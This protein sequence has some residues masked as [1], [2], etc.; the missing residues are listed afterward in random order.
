M[1]HRSAVT[2]VDGNCNVFVLINA[3]LLC[4]KEEDIN[5]ANNRQESE[6]TG[7]NNNCPGELLSVR[8]TFDVLVE[9]ILVQLDDT[10]NH[11]PSVIR[12]S[13]QEAVECFLEEKLSHEDVIAEIE[14]DVAAELVGRH[15]VKDIVD[16]GVAQ[17]NSDVFGFQLVPEIRGRNA[18]D[19]SLQLKGSDAL[20]QH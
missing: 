10:A 19:E 15:V 14:P 17:G 7:D 9:F 4:F 6:H 20:T 18:S 8:I 13:G 2:V 3:D 12:E 5:Y 11:G 16:V 1:L